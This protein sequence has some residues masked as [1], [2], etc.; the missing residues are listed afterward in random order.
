MSGECFDLLIKLQRR[1]VPNLPRGL[2]WL[3]NYSLPSFCGSVQPTN[4]ERCRT[5]SQLCVPNQ[6]VTSES[7]SLFSTCGAQENDKGTELSSLPRFPS[8][9][10][11]VHV[12]ISAWRSERAR[13]YKRQHGSLRDSNPI[14]VLLGR[15]LVDTVTPCER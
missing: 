15:P 3:S 12:P 6:Q 13:R 2:Q 1:F 4:K 8:L 9:S 14:Q 11:S 10:R 5:R 7:C